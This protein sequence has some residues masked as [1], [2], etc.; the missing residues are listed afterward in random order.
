MAAGHL[1]LLLQLLQLLHEMHEMYEMHEMHE[2]Q[3]GPVSRQS[4]SPEAKSGTKM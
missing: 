3:S 4:S 1:Q 2:M